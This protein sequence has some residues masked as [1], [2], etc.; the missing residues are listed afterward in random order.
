PCPC[1]ASR[2]GQ[3]SAAAEAITEIA[4]RIDRIVAEL[5]AQ[6]FAQLAHMALDYILFDLLVENAVDRI[7][8]LRLGDALATVD[9][10]MFENAPLAPRQRKGVAFYFGIATIEKD[11]HLADDCRRLLDRHG[12]ALDGAD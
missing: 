5:A 11:L 1:Y 2:P 8:N 7:E 6:F 12:A 4:L 3:R 9:D 10:K